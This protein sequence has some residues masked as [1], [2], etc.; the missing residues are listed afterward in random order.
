LAWAAQ[1]RALREL[2]TGGEATL[3]GS[4]RAR[5]QG[6]LA[7]ALNAEVRDVDLAM[8]DLTTTDRA[9]LLAVAKRLAQL[10]QR[11]ESEIAPALG[12]VAGTEAADGTNSRFSAGDPAAF[13]GPRGHPST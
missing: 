7:D 9:R 4:L 6:T 12:T 3:A 13:P 5:G 10:K 8:R 1:W 2:A 11:V